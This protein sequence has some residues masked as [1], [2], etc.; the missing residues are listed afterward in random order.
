[1]HIQQ[2]PVSYY[3]SALQKPRNPAIA[4]PHPGPKSLPQKPL[5]FPNQSGGESTWQMNHP[6]DLTPPEATVTKIIRP[7][8]RGRVK[9]QG[10]WWSARCLEPE[11]LYPGEIVWVVGT[12]NITL[13]VKPVNCHRL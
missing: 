9:F 1:M 6:Y 2:L 11:T 3:E 7:H 13:L 10:S 8:Q 4:W 5:Q 12:D